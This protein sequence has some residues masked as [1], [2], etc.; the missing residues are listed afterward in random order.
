MA[1][2]ERRSSDLAGA[3]LDGRSIDWESGS[4]TADDVERP[5]LAQLK[6]LAALATLHRH[7]DDPDP[8]GAE[9]HDTGSVTPLFWG[10]LRVL[11]PIGRGAFGEVTAR[12]TRGSTAR[13]RS[14]CCPPAP[15]ADEARATSIIQEGRL[16]AR[17]RHPN[18]VTIYGAERRRSHR[19][20]DGVRP[21]PHARAA[22]RR[23]E[24][25]EQ[26]EVMSIG[27][28]LCHAMSAVHA[29]G[30]LHRD[31]KAQNVMLADAGRVVLMDFG[32]GRRARRQ[33]GAGRHAALP[34]PEVLRGQ[35]ASVRSDIYG[36]GV[37][38]YTC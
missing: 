36:L 19:L 38:L 16:L 13:S 15:D 10:H 30:L 4:D 23:R 12:G 6:L 5:V 21:R 11:E 32:A 27:V 14:S 25:F 7:S 28:E 31:I 29:A 9:L 3:I 37:L 33:L 24:S 22:A 26:D 18:V 2:G 17:V 8:P 35:A 1:A 20:L 34:G